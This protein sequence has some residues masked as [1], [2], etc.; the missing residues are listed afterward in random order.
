MAGFGLQ[1]SHS[2][3]FDCLKMTTSVCSMQS[4]LI[5]RV[6]IW[7]PCARGS[8]LAG[9]SPASCP[10]PRLHEWGSPV[11]GPQSSRDSSSWRSDPRPARVSVARRRS[12][13]P[14]GA[15]EAV[16][17]GGV[18][19]LAEGSSGR[20]ERRPLPRALPGRPPPARVSQVRPSPP[21]SRTCPQQAAL[22][23]WSGPVPA[24]P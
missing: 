17:A 1:P 5:F 22:A 9:E 6:C 10:Q 11:W 13:R 7:V 16:R 8:P 18:C 2:L 20:C 24:G 19:A 23:T 3:G 14:A 12:A 4:A 21:P 15:L